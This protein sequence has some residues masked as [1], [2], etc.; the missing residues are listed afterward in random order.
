[1]KRVLMDK[2]NP[3]DLKGWIRTEHWRAELYRLVHGMAGCGCVDCQ[4]LYKQIDLSRYSNRVTGFD[5]L[6]FVDQASSTQRESRERWSGGTFSLGDKG[7]D[8]DSRLITER[9]QARSKPPSAK[10]EAL[11]S[12]ST[13]SKASS[14]PKHHRGIMSHNVDDQKSAEGMDIIPSTPLKNTHGQKR[15]P[16]FRDLPIARIE[17]MAAR[18]LSARAIAEELCREGVM[19]SY[20][21]IQRLLSGERVLL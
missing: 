9:G 18:G 19:V 3:L 17:G 12:K 2:E 6:I 7:F 10:T 16:I 15:G 13:A 21:T 1:M 8:S 20:K 5:G 14:V 11:K 4:R